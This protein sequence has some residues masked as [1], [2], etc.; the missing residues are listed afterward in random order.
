MQLGRFIFE[1]AFH[2][3]GLH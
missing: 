1:I 2:M 3:L